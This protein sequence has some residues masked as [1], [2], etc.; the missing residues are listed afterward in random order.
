MLDAFEARKTLVSTWTTHSPRGSCA[1][2]GVAIGAII[3]TFAFMPTL[4]LDLALLLALIAGAAT[5]LNGTN[6]RVVT[7]DRFLKAVTVVRLWPFG[8]SRRTR[9]PFD[10]ITH[11]RIESLPGSW[12]CLDPDSGGYTLR[13]SW[14]VSIATA[15]ARRRPAA[16]YESANRGEAAGLAKHIAAGAG[17]RFIEIQP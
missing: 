11:V 9:I 17:A 1:L 14:K 4:R 7:V 3:F 5:Y 8:I 12:I 15:S 13:A 10:H 16:V 6:D 2:G